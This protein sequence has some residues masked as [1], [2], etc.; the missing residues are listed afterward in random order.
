MRILV[1]IKQVPGTTAVE[2]DADTGVL[3]R[4]GVASK[5]NPYDLYALEAALQLKEQMNAEVCALTMGPPQAESI[6]REALMMGVDKVALIS[7]AALAGADVL[8]TSRALAEGAKQL[9]AFDIVLCGK[10]TTDGDT[11]Q[12]GPELAEFLGI[13]HIANVGSIS[14]VTEESLEV[15]VDFPNTVYSLSVTYPC[16]LT[17]EK[18]SNSPR[19]PSYRRQLLTASW[20]IQTLSLSDFSNS[21][22]AHYGLRGSPTQVERIFPP[23]AKQEN[24]LWQGT[25]VEL[26][27]RVVA[28]LHDRKIIDATPLRLAEHEEAE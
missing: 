27:D 23:A 19:L 2:V 13:P 21:D 14:A 11:A 22:P 1:C 9:G 4:I 26:A 5:L 15:T 28:L 12:V 17:M 6:L 24:Q 10:Q 16:L 20:Q 7:D 8:A 3:K 18:G 25:A